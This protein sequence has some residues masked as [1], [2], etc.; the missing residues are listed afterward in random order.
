M[1]LIKEYKS[2]I[3]SNSLGDG[4]RMTTGII[5][6]AII[7][8]YLGYL[9]IGIVAAVGAMCVSLADTSGPIH[10]RVNGMAA[11]FTIGFIVALL[12]GFTVPH[13][14]LLGILIPFICF[15]VSMLGV[16]GSRANAVGV[17]VLMIMVLTIERKNQGW[18]V[19]YNALYIFGGGLWYMLMSLLLYRARPYKIPQQVLGNC[20]VATASYLR[21]R[22]SF[23]DKHVDYEKSYRQ[24]LEQQIDVQG[25]QT[26]VRELL[27]KTRSIITDSTNTGRILLMIFRDTI[28]LFERTMTSHQDYEALHKAFNQS[29]LLYRIQQLILEAA[30]ELDEIG[31]AVKSG[32]ASN[33]KGLLLKNFQE[34]HAYF[35]EFRDI[36]RTPENV[37]GF[38][39]IRHLL[40][41]IEDII[42]RI[43]TLHLYTTYDKKHEKKLPSAS[44]YE[45]FITHTVIDLKLVKDNLSFDSNTFRHAIRIS[46][47]TLCG[48][49]ISK[50]LPVGHSY[51][52]LL[53]IVVILK[54]AYSL[55]KQRSYQRL[56]GTIAGAVVGVIIL[57]FVKD[58]T[59]LFV[60]MSLLMV[61]AYSLIRTKYF[62][63]ILFLTPYI[64]ILFHLLSHVRTE[65]ILIDRVIDTAIGSVIAFLANFFLIPAWEKGQIKNYMV[66]ALTE[67]ANY[68]RRIA[69]AYTGTPVSIT[70][71]K[72]S[73]KGAFVSLA[74]LSDAF[75][76]MLSEPKNKQENSKQI[77][78]FVVLNHMLTSHIA[79]LSYYAEPLAGK[80]SSE[81]FAPIIAATSA[82][83]EEA[84]DALTNEENSITAKNEEERNN[85][86]TKQVNELMLKRR[87]EL[88]QNLLET[89]TKQ[90][91]SEFKSIVD[92]FNFII[93]VATDIKKVSTRFYLEGNS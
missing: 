81:D 56:L 66:Q 62:A 39:N 75:T 3:N 92:Q 87:E 19:V 67:N 89:P 33:D 18:F 29:D 85:I 27:F 24:M 31:L 12:T 60:I 23:Y 72:L 83:F 48:Y 78:Q 80:Y 5:L 44:E 68:F 28:D 32:E 91:L 93:R 45:K 22:A 55:S 43:H 15:S 86:L 8:N 20:I 41:G 7:L 2:F 13:P 38:I 70:Q 46:I 50:F 71:Y 4:V 51:W 40:N 65:S 9:P 59:A 25:K 52:I 77:Y 69:S 16:Y 88:Q 11:C 10:H 49:I 74:N 63:S 34:L 82:Q 30:E 17:G 21:I 58:D 26:L 42:S 90:T 84:I 1:D 79:T 57:F 76:R 61:A 64:M 53:T 47:A 37:E 54:P 14:I 73:R 36:N 6:P 35:E